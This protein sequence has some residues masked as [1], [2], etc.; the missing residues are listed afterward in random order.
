MSLPAHLP[1]VTPA[2]RFSLANI[3]RSAHRGMAQSYAM[4]CKL[5]ALDG[6]EPSR[7]SAWKYA[8]KGV[9]A[10]ARAE[11]AAWQ[12]ANG[13]VGIYTMTRDGTLA[14]VAPVGFIAAAMVDAAF[15]ARPNNPS[16]F[17]GLEQRIA[18]LAAGTAA[19]VAQ[20]AA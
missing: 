16:A 10:T 20:A 6:T 14:P 1:L 2:G 8:L 13:R 9:W 7:A 17:E 4:E 18:A 5:A 19:P 15:R 12:A 3:M 11:L